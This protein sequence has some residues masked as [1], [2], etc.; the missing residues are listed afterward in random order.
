MDSNGGNLSES[1]RATTTAAAVARGFHGSV[2]PITSNVGLLVPWQRAVSCSQR[3][4]KVRQSL[5][6]LC[7]GQKGSLQAEYLS[8][9]EVQ[10]G[11]YSFEPTGNM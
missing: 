10:C 6:V 1:Q 7:T 2:L 5:E 9:V 3:H 8:I 11:R 4:S